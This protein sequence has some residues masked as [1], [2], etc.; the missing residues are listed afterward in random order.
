MP[1]IATAEAVRMFLIAETILLPDRIDFFLL[2]SSFFLLPSSFLGGFHP[3]RCV[4]L[5]SVKS[6]RAGYFVQ[7]LIA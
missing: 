1:N 4:S 5:M 7:K 3:T 2:P 6:G